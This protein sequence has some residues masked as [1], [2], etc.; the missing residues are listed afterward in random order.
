MDE[1]TGVNPQESGSTTTYLCGVNVIDVKKGDII[2]RATIVVE[3]GRVTQVARRIPATQRDGSVIDLDG[4]YAVPGLWN[5][6]THLGGMFP[7]N[8]RQEHHESAADRTIRAGSNLLTALVCGIT[9]VRVVG[10]AA[11][12]D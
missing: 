2:P 9:G 3:D 6:H 10:D 1:A 7:D 5:V 8:Y 11:G 12:V 4:A